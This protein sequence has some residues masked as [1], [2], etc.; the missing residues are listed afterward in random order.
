MYKTK[1]Q[2]VCHKRQWG[3]PKYSAM[4]DG[5]D[6]TPCFKASVY[7]NGISFH[8]SASCK[9]S[10]E[11]H[12]DAAKMAFLHFTSPPPPSSF[13]I[14]GTLADGPETNETSQ[15]LDSHSSVSDPKNYTP[16]K[17]KSHLQNYAR[18]KNCDLPM[19][20]NT[21][22]GPSHAPCFK[23]TVTVDGHTIES[24]EFFNTLKAAEHAAA[25][26]A[27]MSLSTNGF[28]EAS[29]FN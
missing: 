21:R 29:L 4:K 23:A 15:E 19:Y 10:K 24:P 20:S 13:M 7:V 11:A 18:W 5:P 28:L 16:L 12:N 8:S 6:H 25:K 9:S 3:L 17:Y 27:L 14:P 22:E 26:A 2:E 1:L